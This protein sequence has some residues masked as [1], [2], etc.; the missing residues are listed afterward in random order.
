MVGVDR[1]VTTFKRVSRRQQN[2]YNR[3]RWNYH[4]FANTTWVKPY[5]HWQ[6]RVKYD[7][8]QTGLIKWV[9]AVKLCLRHYSQD[10]FET[11]FVV[12]DGVNAL[13]NLNMLFTF[14]TNLKPTGV[15]FYISSCMCW[16]NMKYTPNVLCCLLNNLTST[17][18]HFTGCLLINTWVLQNNL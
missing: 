4:C 16:F 10:C 9:V 18:I 6:I 12:V 17:K 13:S 11:R 15:I 7:L 5:Y 1:Y 8:R 3:R 14:T 2:W